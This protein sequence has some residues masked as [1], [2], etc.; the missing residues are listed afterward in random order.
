MSNRR[1]AWP[2]AGAAAQPTARAGDPDG[3]APARDDRLSFASQLA[4]RWKEPKLRKGERSRRAIKAAAAALLETSGY[5]EL[6]VHDIVQRAD[7]SNALFYVHYTNKQQLTYEILSEFLQSLRPLGRDIHL[8]TGPEAIFASHYTYVH[9]F[10]A[11]AGLMRCLLQFGDEVEAFSDL[12]RAFND[13]WMERVIRSFRKDA[14]VAVPDRAE[15][16]VTCASLGMM[17]DGLLRAAFVERYR[18]LEEDA[19]TIVGDGLE[20]ALVLTRIWVRTLY[21]KDLDWRP[22]AELVAHLEARLDAI[23]QLLPTDRPATGQTPAAPL[24]A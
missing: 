14:D 23:G 20:L 3:E 8:Q 9:Q 6:R 15:L 17:V 21:L 16:L 11:N 7:V 2:A 10:R 13:S 19:S 1:D 18:R 5:A 4:Q 12:W 22:S 24:E